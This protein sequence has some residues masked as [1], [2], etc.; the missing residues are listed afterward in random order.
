L[1]LEFALG[2]TERKSPES[3]EKGV[4]QM[5]YQHSMLYQHFIFLRKGGK[6]KS[7]KLLSTFN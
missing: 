1:E 5:L 7:C 4:K 2:R 3:G 6:A